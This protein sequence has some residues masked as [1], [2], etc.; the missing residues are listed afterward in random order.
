MK[1]LFSLVLILLT[2][3]CTGQSA[4]NPQTSSSTAPI[5]ADHSI[6]YVVETVLEGL[7]VPWDMD[8]AVDGRLFFTERSGAVRVMDQGKLMP[9]TVYTLSDDFFSKGEGGLLGLV[10]DPKFA[11]NH[12]IYVYHTYEEKGKINNRVLRLVE[13]DNTAKLDSVLISNLPGGQNH[14]GGRIKIGP[15]G[16]L[17]IAAGDRYEPTLAQDPASLGGKILRIALDGR[18][19]AD[20]PVPG[21]PVYS[22]GHRNPQGFAW[23]PVTGKLFSSEHG[24]SAYDEI[25]IIEPGMNYGWPMIEGDEAFAERPE[26]LGPL[27]H[28]NNKTWAPSGMTFIT[29]GPWKGQLLVANLR[30]NQILKLTLGADYTSVVEVESLFTELGR[31]RNVYEAT[32]G[33]VYIMTNNRDERGNPQNGDDKLIRLKPNF[34]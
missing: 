2:V 26:L 1:R 22:M 10:L 21:S 5:K 25:N 4:T 13:K 15:D 24:Q 3:G 33:S 23:H 28:S 11:T 7:D 8:I 9:D 19:P 17:Y 27:I 30:G 14:N 31:I 16:N 29:Q 12:Y 20:N 32:D 18:I 34:E 6:P